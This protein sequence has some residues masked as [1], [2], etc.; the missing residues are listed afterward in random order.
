MSIFKKSKLQDE[1]INNEML[2]L[3]DINKKLNEFSNSNID[4]SKIFKIKENFINKINDFYREDRK[5][6]IGIIGQ[7]KAGK[8]SFLNSLLFK[9]KDVL[10]KAVIPKTAVL[11]KIEYSER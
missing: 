10:S 3:E 5:L 11:T 2:K 7:I 9:G 6:N 4:T 8:S 1:I